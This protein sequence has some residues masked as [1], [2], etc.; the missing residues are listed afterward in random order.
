MEHDNLYHQPIRIESILDL[1]GV[2]ESE[3]FMN[4]LLF[5]TKERRREMHSMRVM[6]S[7]NKAV[8]KE[9]QK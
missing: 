6:G 9:Q 8:K 2:A 7:K 4:S 3:R 5:N 1:M